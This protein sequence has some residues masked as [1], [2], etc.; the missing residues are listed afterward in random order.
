MR[1]KEGEGGRESER[2]ERDR[3]THRSTAVTEMLK[4]PQA[5]LGFLLQS[6]EPPQQQQQQ[7]QMK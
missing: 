6:R 5:I 7:T 1:E 3:G 2:G 4:I